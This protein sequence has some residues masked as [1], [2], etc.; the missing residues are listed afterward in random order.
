MRWKSREKVEEEDYE[1]TPRKKITYVKK[2]NYVEKNQLF[3]SPLKSY[4]KELFFL[5]VMQ[6]T[7]FVTRYT[8]EQYL[9]RVKYK[10]SF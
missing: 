3:F 1:C 7:V 10:N 5:R 2:Y 6:Q 8:K 4:T 9:S